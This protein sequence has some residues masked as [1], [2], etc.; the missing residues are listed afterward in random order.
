MEL[1]QYKAKQYQVENRLSTLVE[2]SR[3]FYP[4]W[5]LYCVST[6]VEWHTGW[7]FGSKEK[8]ASPN[9]GLLVI[10]Q[11]KNLCITP[12]LSFV[13]PPPAPLDIYVQRPPTN[14]TT[15]NLQRPPTKYGHHKLVAKYPICN[16]PNVDPA[17]PIKYQNRNDECIDWFASNLQYPQ[18]IRA[19]T[20][21]SAGMGGFHKQ[22]KDDPNSEN[23]WSI[24]DSNFHICGTTTCC[25]D[26]SF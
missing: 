12:G 13:L 4:S 11:D 26:F 21:T 15:S 2:G 8:D 22:Y 18:A 9:H 23:I 14:D 10:S 20:P 25:D 7:V 1:L 17:Q 24:L 16:N 6:A 5:K 3:H 19:R